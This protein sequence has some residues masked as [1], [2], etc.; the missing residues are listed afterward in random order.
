MRIQTFVSGALVGG[1]TGLVTGTA[2][3]AAGTTGAKRPQAD[4]TKMSVERPIEAV[5]KNASLPIERPA[6]VIERQAL[7][8][9]GVTPGLV[10]WHSSFAE[11][12]EASTRT[13]KPVLLFQLLGKLDHQFC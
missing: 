8:N 7:S 2:L 13:H 12:C 6:A 5:V 10:C 11:A 1:I 3:W 9:P 4:V